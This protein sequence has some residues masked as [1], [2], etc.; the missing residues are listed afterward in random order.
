MHCQVPV[1]NDE[2]Q[3]D[4]EADLDYGQTLRFMGTSEWGHKRGNDGYNLNPCAYN[5]TY[6]YPQTLDPRPSTLNPASKYP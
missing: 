6:K 1:Q 4:D 2:G 3:H 5:P